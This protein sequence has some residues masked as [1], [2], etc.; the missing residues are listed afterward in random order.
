MTEVYSIDEAFLD[1]H[2]LPADRPAA[3][4]GDMAQ[5]RRG[6]NRGH[7]RADLLPKAARGRRRGRA[8]GARAGDRP[9]RQH[10]RSRGRHPAGRRPGADADPLSAGGP[11]GYRSAGRPVRC[12]H[13]QQRPAPHAL[14]RSRP[15]PLGRTEVASRPGR[16]RPRTRLGPPPG[17]GSPV[18]APRR[19]P[20]GAAGG[21]GALPLLAAR[22]LHGRGNPPPAARGR[23][24]PGGQRRWRAAPRSGRP[25]VVIARTSNRP[26]GRPGG[27]P[28]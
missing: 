18:A 14:R 20:Q 16:G 5:G 8:E 4:A 23:P 25:A 1:L 24:P 7:R 2:G 3:I 19:T 13:Q 26:S 15:R 11:Q 22:G 12:A 27:R 28:T 6:A 17:R 9:L 21:A 10:A